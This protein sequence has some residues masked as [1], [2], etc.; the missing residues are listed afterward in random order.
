MRSGEVATAGGGRGREVKSEEWNVK[1]EVE[2]CEGV[3]RTGRRVQ[4]KMVDVEW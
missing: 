2:K 4:V 3:N 1:S